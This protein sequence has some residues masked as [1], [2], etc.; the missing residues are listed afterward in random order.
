MELKKLRNDLY[1][2]KL[3]TKRGLKEK[4]EIFFKKICLEVKKNQKKSPILEIKKATEIVKPFYEIQ[5]KK[6]RTKTTKIPFE[7]KQ[8]KQQLLATQFFIT[9]LKENKRNFFH[10]Q[11]LDEVIGTLNL[12][13]ASLKFCEN[14]QKMV[15]INKIFIEY[16]F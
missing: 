7:I 8:K 14:F 1:K 9:G 10:K 4:T 3:F 5:L 11:L 2:I 15:E 16:R 13:S 12:T 6:T